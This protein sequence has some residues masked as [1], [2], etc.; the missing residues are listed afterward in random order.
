MSA[1]LMGLSSATLQGI[2]VHLGL[3]DAHYTRQI[4]AMVCTPTPLSL[5]LRRLKL[6][7]LC[8]LSLQFL[9]QRTDVKGTAASDLV[10]CLKYTGL[11]S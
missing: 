11:Q 2:I 7:N 1:F 5:S 4:C 10:D 3:I 8:L 9:G 6:L